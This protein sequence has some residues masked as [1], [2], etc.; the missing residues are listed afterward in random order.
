MRITKKLFIIVLNIVLIISIL[1][2][3]SFAFEIE[4]ETDYIW[5]QEEISSTSS[6]ATT[7][8]NL[9]SRYAIV[10]DRNSKAVLYEK[11]SNERVPMASTTKIMTAI[12]LLESLEKD[13]NLTLESKIE[14]CKEAGAIGGSRLGLKTG[15]K[16][17]VN[18]LLYGLMLCSG[19][20]AA[21]QIAVSIG[22]SVEGFA[23]LMNEKAKELGLKDSHFVTP[24]GL[25]MEGHY[26]T[27]Y[28]LALIADYAL[29]IE[30]FSEVVKTKTY[31]VMINGY[32]KNISNT[33]ELLGY[34]NGVNGVKTGFTNGAG[35]CLVTSANRNGFNIITVVLG[36]DTKKIR[37]KDSIALIEYTY[38]NYE[39]V[40]LEEIINE[41]FDEWRRV[42]EKRIYVYKGKKSNIKTKLE[43]YEYKIYPVKKENIKDI[44]IT[45][46]NINTFFE[47]PVDKNNLVAKL[48]VKIGEKEILTLN[49]LTDEE[50]DRKD[51]R[52]YFFECL[53]YQQNWNF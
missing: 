6:N 1:S 13:N 21:V 41:K 25:D 47:A 29:N 16:V 30:K 37:T 18:D 38:S 40:N 36:A 50:V 39:L 26:T 22:G 23:N 8:P 42:N 51:V 46:E 17:S 2:F 19:N 33:N 27:A 48:T 44:Q 52:D 3:K 24:H 32:S 43:D 4:E 34:L 9:N 53:I 31:T 11:N 7:E 35:R 15:D 5:L 14:V 12:V 45:I 49:L 10:L 28:E 20:D